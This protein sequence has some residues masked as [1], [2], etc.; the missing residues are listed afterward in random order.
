MCS[1]ELCGSPSGE[2][3]KTVFWPAW[4]GPAL[5]LTG[6]EPLLLT[7]MDPPGKTGGS[8]F[9]SRN[10]EGCGK[11]RLASKELGKVKR[12][13]I[14]LEWEKPFLLDGSISMSTSGSISVSADDGGE[15][16]CIT[17]VQ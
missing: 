10:P 9:V 17:R 2:A 8:D 13:T 12:L 14:Y 6:S 4:V 3:G 11:R 5:P 1:A 15:T 16:A 7:E